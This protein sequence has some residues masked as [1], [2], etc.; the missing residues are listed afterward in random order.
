MIL[1]QFVEGGT[2]IITVAF[3]DEDGVAVTPNTL[4]YTLIRDGKIVNSRENVT[5]TPSSTVYIVLYGNDLLA[6][7]TKIIVEGTYDSSSGSNLPIKKWDCFEV[8][9]MP[10][11]SA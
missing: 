6:G 10:T 2:E 5:L 8:L 7:T 3:T 9:A 4:A 1:P 11:I